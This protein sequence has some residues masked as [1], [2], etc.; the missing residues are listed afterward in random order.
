MPCDD[1]PASWSPEYPYFPN[2]PP[3]DHH[4]CANPVEDG[5]PGLGTW[6]AANVPKE[7]AKLTDQKI[8]DNCLDHLRLAKNVSEEHARANGGTPRPF[9]VACGLHK[10]HVPWVAPVEFY[11]NVLPWEETPTAADPWAPVG[12]PAVA[13]HPPADVKGMDESPAFNGT[14]NMTRSA[15]YRAA[16]YAATSYQDYN[17]GVILAELEWL[18]LY[19]NTTVVLFGDHGWQLGEHDTWAKMTNFEIATHIPLIIRCPWLP[20]SVGKQTA[21]REDGDVCTE[22]SSK[23]STN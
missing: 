6:C 15:Q 13:W 10:P 17:I 19:Q 20:N 16:Y 11:N 8:R 5:A 21:V 22:R 1:Y 23:I 9:F 7:G 18:G 4:T 2:Q 14:V 3:N 12:M